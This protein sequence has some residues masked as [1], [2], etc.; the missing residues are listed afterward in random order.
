MIRL[1]C[2]IVMSVI[3]SDDFPD[4]GRILPA[5]SYFF[6]DQP[7]ITIIYI[8]P[9]RKRNID[10]QFLEIIR[11]FVLS[12]LVA[13]QKDII[14]MLG[15]ICAECAV[16]IY[17]R[18]QRR[19]RR[20]AGNFIYKKIHIRSLYRIWRPI[21]VCRSLILAYVTLV[22]CCQSVLRKWYR[23]VYV[24]GQCVFLCQ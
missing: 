9:G 18:F 23:G 14:V 24:H 8:Q 10:L 15:L 11:D 2:H 7:V 6:A 1:K 4:A 5:S 21:D 20:A 17:N 13:R 22:P 3:Q 19:I 12:C 16:A